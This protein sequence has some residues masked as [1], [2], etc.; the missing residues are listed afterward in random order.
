VQRTKE[1]VETLKTINPAILVE[2]E[3]GDIGV[4]SEIHEEVRDQ[5]AYPRVP[6]GRGVSSR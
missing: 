1:G 4:G 3:I 5:S 6:D 2:G